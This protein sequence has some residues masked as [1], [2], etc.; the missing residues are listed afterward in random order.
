[1]SWKFWNNVKNV[2]LNSVNLKIASKG[3]FYLMGPKFSLFLSFLNFLNDSK[4]NFLE[5]NC[6]LVFSM[7]SMLL[8]WSFFFSFYYFCLKALVAKTPQMQTIPFSWHVK[9]RVREAGE[10]QRRREEIWFYSHDSGINAM[11]SSYHAWHVAQHLST[12]NGFKV[13][14]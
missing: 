13:L 3:N 5:L 11:L 14:F 6:L 7:C 2:S 9:W 1:M 8:Y 12:L 4:H 10:N